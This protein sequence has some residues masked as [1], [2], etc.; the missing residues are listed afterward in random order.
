[1]FLLNDSIRRNVTL[2]DPALTDADVERALKL[3]GAWDFVSKIPEGLDWE[4]GE[5][6]ARL[7]GGQRQRIAI[8]RAL[9]TRPTLLI[10]DEVTASV[11]PDTERAI[12]ETLVSLRGQVTILAI[13]HQPAMRRVADRAY[14]MRRGRLEPLTANAANDEDRSFG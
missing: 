12:C 5:R 8:A 6:G 7:S 3:A 14:R 13:S 10:L 9:V 1:M 11:D 4:V 2:G